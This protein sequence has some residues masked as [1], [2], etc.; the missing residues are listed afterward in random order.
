MTKQV[1]YSIVLFLIILIGWGV[2]RYFFKLPEWADEL[3][4]KP[5]VWLLPTILL[6]KVIERQSLASIGFVKTNFLRNALLGLLLGVFISL[7]GLGVRMFKYG[8]VFNP[9]SLPIL[10][11]LSVLALSFVTGF[12]EEV[13]FRG[14]IMNRLWQ[15]LNNELLA[16]IISTVLF[17]AVHIPLMIFV[18][19]YSLYESFTYGSLVF[20]LGAVDAFIFARTKSLVAPTVSHAI[21]NFAAVMFR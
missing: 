5:F 16:N 3:I 9:D 6:V 8:V 4:A 18:L 10:L 15:G 7:E 19:H 14:Y 13:A 1:K 17:V 20:V 12:I 21:W 11:M 2:Y